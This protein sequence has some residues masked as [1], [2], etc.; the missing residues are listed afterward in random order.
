ML[1]AGSITSEDLI[2]AAP[3][4]PRRN[5]CVKSPNPYIRARGRFKAQRSQF[6]R[7]KKEDYGVGK[8]RRSREGEGEGGKGKEKEDSRTEEGGRRGKGKR[9]GKGGRRNSTCF[10]NENILTDPN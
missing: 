1:A 10:G 6:T 9:R 4:M 2:T 5:S 8:R 7:Q 3:K